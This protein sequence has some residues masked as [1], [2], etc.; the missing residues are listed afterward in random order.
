M[1][2]YYIADAR[3]HTGYYLSDRNDR[4]FRMPCDAFETG[5]E[6]FLSSE[7]TEVMCQG[8]YYKRRK[9]YPYIKDV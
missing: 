3:I 9:I 1:A 8:C 7:N 5:R 4:I 6:F 2:G